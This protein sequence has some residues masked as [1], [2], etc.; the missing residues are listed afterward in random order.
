MSREN[1]M[2]RQ[3]S[4]EGGQTLVIVALAL[5]PL[6][7]VAGLVIDG[8]WAFAQ[9]RRTQN[10]MDAAANAGA[11]VILQN[12]PFTSRGATPPRT[13]RNVHDQILAVA[14]SNGISAE[15][16]TAVYTG[17]DGRP[18]DPA[19]PVGS[20]GDVPPPENAY[21][22]AVHGSQDFS[23]FFA[24]IA[25]MSGFRASADATAIAGAITSICAS[26]Q[27]CSFIPVTFPTQLTDC[28]G[29]GRQALGS[30][31]Y[32]V[33]VPPA[34]FT[35]ANELI[36]PLCGTASGS[37]GWLDIQPH[38]PLC[39][40]NGA[41]ELACVIANPSRTSMPIP[42]W[43]G[44]QTGNINSS[45]V[46][47]ALDAYS[48][49]VVGTYE[50]GRDLIVQIPIYDCIDN[51][52][53]QP[54]SNVPC[55]ATEPNGIGSN[56]SYHIIG[57]LAFVLDHSYINAT[58]PECNQTPGGPFVGGNGSNGCLKGWLTQISTSG[59]VGLPTGNLQSV[60]GVQL[61]R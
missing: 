43:I 6:L 29:T 53:S 10:A 39:N 42:L 57:I 33:I 44:T 14:A 20:L 18:L 30:S 8:G 38:N 22:V 15:D 49:V 19:V 55:P 25:G 4:R 60:W 24:G 34:T 7:L 12:L 5:I 47:S 36:I 41:A 21:G 56:T 61:V 54:S 52:I 31:Q 48:G 2:H 9:Q 37:V 59:T 23:T 58:N 51:N 3:E 27:P 46:Q 50:P 11:V 40:G 28:T 35:A 26:N 1:P 45:Q 13:D 17:I 16:P 32:Q